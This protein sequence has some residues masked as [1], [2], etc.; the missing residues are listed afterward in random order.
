M[1]ELVVLEHIIADGVKNKD[2]KSVNNIRAMTANIY[3]GLMM[4]IFQ[5]NDKKTKLEDI[6]DMLVDR[7]MN[8]YKL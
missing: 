1:S 5:H 7:F 8:G 2:I 4:M 3:F 6:V